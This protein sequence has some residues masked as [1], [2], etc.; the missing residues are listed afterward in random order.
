MFFS[1]TKGENPVAWSEMTC[2]QYNLQWKVCYNN[3]HIKQKQLLRRWDN[4]WKYRGVY[5]GGLEKHIHTNNM[6]VIR[7]MKRTR[8]QELDYESVTQVQDFSSLVIPFTYFQSIQCKDPSIHLSLTFL[9]SQMSLVSIDFQ[10][11]YYHH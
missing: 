9:S 1:L 4:L 5:V 3:L 6:K 11:C 8:R 10:H 7:L 2:M